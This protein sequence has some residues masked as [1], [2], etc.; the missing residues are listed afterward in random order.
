MIKQQLQEIL[1]DLTEEDGAKTEL[2]RLMGISLQ[3]ISPSISGT[4]SVSVKRLEQM[5]KLLGYEIFVSVKKKK[6]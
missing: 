6:S 4:R 5:I 3:E 2:A 1:Q